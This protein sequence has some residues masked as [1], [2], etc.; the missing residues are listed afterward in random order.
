MEGKEGKETEVCISFIWIQLGE[1]EGRELEGEAP[2]YFK[3]YITFHIQ[4]I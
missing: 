1:M 4:K 3:K 2:S